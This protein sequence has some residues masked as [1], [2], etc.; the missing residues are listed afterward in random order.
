MALTGLPKNEDDLAQQSKDI[1]RDVR[2]VLSQWSLGAHASTK[3]E[4]R[5]QR[6]ILDPAIKFHQDFTSSSRRYTMETIEDLGNLSPKEMLNEWNLK[7]VDTWGQVKKED[8]VGTALYCLHPALVRRRPGGA[9]PVT[10]V[11]PVVVIT[12]PGTERI[13][14]KQSKYGPL[15]GNATEQPASTKATSTKDRTIRPPEKNSLASTASANSSSS[16]ADSESDT[17]SER[18]S[19][20]KDELRSPIGQVEENPEQISDAQDSDPADVEARH[21]TSETPGFDSAVRPGEVP[22]VQKGHKPYRYQKIRDNPLA[23]RRALRGSKDSS[24]GVSPRGPTVNKLRQPTSG[25]NSVPIS[26]SSNS[27]GPSKDSPKENPTQ[28]KPT[29]DNPHLSTSH[30]NS[31]PAPGQNN[32]S[33][34]NYFKEKLGYNVKDR[35]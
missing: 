19:S 14:N 32:G 10:I 12:R 6:R 24:G 34:L 8:Q 3:L 29:G 27:S 5:F 17:V 7:A 20:E 33:F 25:L 9:D 23:P 4:A 31:V 1:L 11:K 13:L 16:E 28:H 21:Y 35:R 22:Y 26:P 15:H 2:S 18:E 30:S